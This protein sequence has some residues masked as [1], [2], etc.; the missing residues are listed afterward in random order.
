MLQRGVHKVH[1]VRAL[2]RE[3]CAEIPRSVASGDASV[4]EPPAGQT[5][6]TSINTHLRIKQIYA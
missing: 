2:S 3:A 4:P 5:S 6:R 1:I